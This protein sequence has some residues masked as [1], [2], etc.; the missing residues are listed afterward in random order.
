M[1]RNIIRGDEK[2]S[3]GVHGYIREKTES[4]SQDS[5]AG[6]PKHEIH[7][8]GRVQV[9]KPGVHSS[10]VHSSRLESHKT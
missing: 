7:D 10:T 9:M 4:R 3:S 8:K 5:E 2:L 6:K 1:M